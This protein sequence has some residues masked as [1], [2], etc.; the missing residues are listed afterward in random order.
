MSKVE[1]RNIKGIPVYFIANKDSKFT[2]CRICLNV[3]SCNEDKDSYGVAHFLEHMIFQGTLSKNKHQLNREMQL[4]GNFNAYTY[5]NNTQYLFNS[6]N[7]DFEESFRLLKESVFDCSL[8]EEEIEKER[9]VILEE[10][11]MYNNNPSSYFGA[12]LIEDAFG[13]EMHAIIGSPDSIKSITREKIMRF[14]NKWYGRENMYIIISSDL[15]EQQ[16]SDIIDSVLPEIPSVEKA[17]F[18]KNEI[19]FSEKTNILRVNDYHQTIYASIGRLP[20]IKERFSRAN[21][22]PFFNVCLNQKLYEILRDDYGISYSPQIS[23]IDLP[24]GSF[25]YSF[26]LTSSDK[27]DLIREK[28]REI[29]DDIQQNGFSEDILKLARKQIIIASTRCLQDSDSLIDIFEDKL[30]RSNDIDWVVENFDKFSSIEY[31][32]ECSNFTNEDMI[33]FAKDISPMDYEYSMI[34]MIEEDSFCEEV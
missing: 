20:T 24:G 14:K 12:K 7:E 11:Y 2:E 27:L 5:Y 18:G 22:F 1:V 19:L 23:Y 4:L 31:T 34:S 29:L 21:I 17:T 8:P 9:E 30:T 26:I 33:N 16:L 3:G 25:I 32:R 15:P 13:E 28:L 6:L 10:A